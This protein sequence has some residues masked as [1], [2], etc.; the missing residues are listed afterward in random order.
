MP[1]CTLGRNNKVRDLQD[2]VKRWKLAKTDAKVR[3]ETQIWDSVYFEETAGGV[4]VTRGEQ[5]LLL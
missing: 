3:G 1:H 5:V 4:Y 2:L